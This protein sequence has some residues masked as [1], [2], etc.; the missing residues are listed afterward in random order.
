MG[1]IVGLKLV[2]HPVLVLVFALWLGLPPA[3]TAAA[4]VFAA[5]PAGV[6]TYLF[7]KLYGRGVRQASLAIAVTSGAA[8]VTITAWLA[9]LQAL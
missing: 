1:A 4:V 3:W 5:C 6:N 9:V 8:L 2:V 7:A